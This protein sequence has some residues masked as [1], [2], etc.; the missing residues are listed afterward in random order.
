MKYLYSWL[1][2][3]YPEL[4]NL[5]QLESVLVQ[6]G[7][8]V[9]SI[10]PVARD[11]LVVA[12]IK[13]IQ[14]HPNGEKLSCVTVDTGLSQLKIVCGAKNLI[15]KQKVVL[16][17]PGTTLPSGNKI[18]ITTIR[19]EQSAGMLCSGEDLG[20]NSSNPGLFI[21][22]EDAPIGE[23]AKP[24]LPLDAVITLD[25]TSDRGDVLSHFGLARDLYALK[26]KS[27]LQFNFKVPALPQ[28]N[29]QLQLDTIHPDCRGI[30]FVLT[31]YDAAIQTPMLWQCRLSLVGQKCIN[32]PT[33]LTN[34]IMLSFGQPLHAYDASRLTSYYFGV[35][36][37]HDGERFTT[38]QSKQLRLTPQNLVI[39]A[40]DNPIA[41]AGVMGSQDTGTTARSTQVVFEAASFVPKSISL[42]ARG[43]N[44]LTDAALRFERHI[45]E[46]SRHN[47]FDH[48]MALWCD[49]TGGSIVATT[50][51]KPVP[52]LKSEFVGNVVELVDYIGSPLPYTKIQALLESIGCL[53]THTDDT[54]WTIVSPSWRHDLVNMEDYA[55]EIIRLVD[56]NKLAK[57]PLSPSVPQW[58]RSP[59]WKNEFLKDTLVAL[60]LTEI[61]TYPFISLEEIQLLGIDQQKSLELCEAPIGNKNF[62]RTNLTPSL[63]KAVADN[64]ETP[65]ISLFEIAK[66]YSTEGEIEQIGIV[67]A[68]NSQTQIDIKWQNMFE[69]LRLPVSSWMSRIKNIEPNVFKHYKIR[70]PIVTILEMPIE[71]FN[72]I[73]TFDI[74]PV[75]IADLDSM[76]IKPISHFQTSRRDV[77]VIVSKDVDA[78]KLAT[79]ILRWGKT[80]NIIETSIFDVYRDPAMGSEKQSI[81]IR[82]TFQAHD[83]TLTQ[84]E[85]NDYQSKLNQYLQ[86]KYHGIIR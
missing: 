59:Y 40:A 31:T 85:L 21:L 71:Q 67:L 76:E 23:S 20:I 11:G 43:L 24:F 42:S 83:H 70:K 33:D 35:R 1:Q 28:S 79:D 51:S 19:G 54:N 81:S 7:H 86:E 2:D 84:T 38:F 41:L 32:L 18:Q 55:E 58:K 62:L 78:Y 74:L 4:P 44:L 13:D 26:A 73:K 46:D 68:S 29:S 10:T 9:E 14:P 65:H 47:I 60:G 82:I 53:I 56:I 48:A 63:L 34:Y 66:V 17:T 72:Q 57:K 64:P 30:S 36:R 75:A 12:E 52:I 8:D 80:I 22:P 15:T 69:R 61:Q 39:T 77:S 50:A 49:V 37:A 27:V 25:I 6:L 16:A 5:D 45:D 3:Y